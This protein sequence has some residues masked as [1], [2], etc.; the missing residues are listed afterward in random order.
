[1]ERKKQGGAPIDWAALDPVSLSQEGIGLAKIPVNPNTAK[2]F[3]EFAL[4]KEGQTVVR[5]FGRIPARLEIK[6]DPP[7]LTEGV[8]MVPSDPN[9]GDEVPRVLKE[10]NAI[11]K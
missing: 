9:L 3:I 8:R 11:F 6:P 4:S 2:L 7:K 10:F 1:M 5:E